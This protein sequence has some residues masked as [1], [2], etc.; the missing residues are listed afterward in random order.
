MKIAFK[1]FLYESSQEDSIGV[2]GNII[3]ESITP[4]KPSRVLT[5]TG[6]N[7]AGTNL[8]SKKYFKEFTTSKG[9]LV[10]VFFKK[11]ATLDSLTVDFAVNDSYD[12]KDRS[13]DNEVLQGVLYVAKKY[14]DKVKPN[15]IS[16]AINNEDDR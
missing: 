8:A 6:T 1:G 16:L 2:D 11:G 9:N 10:K 7:N 14:V 4:K 15:I 5:K 13:V 3:R 12:V